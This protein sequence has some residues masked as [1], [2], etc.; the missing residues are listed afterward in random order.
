MFSGEK[1]AAV[2]HETENVN[3][4]DSVLKVSQWLLQASNY[5]MAW[6]EILLFS[7]FS[8][9]SS[10]IYD[11]GLFPVSPG[12]LINVGNAEPSSSCL[13]ASSMMLCCKGTEKI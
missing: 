6:P 2:F 11:G 1:K 7:F 5:D 10:Q 8:L 13:F 3:L 4:T 12:N 9:N